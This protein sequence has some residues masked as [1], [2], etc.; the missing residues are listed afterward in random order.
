MAGTDRHRPFVC[1]LWMDAD[2]NQ[3]FAKANE[4]TALEEMT[5]ELQAQ[6]FRTAQRCAMKTIFPP[7]ADACH[8]CASRI[9][10]RVELSGH[11]H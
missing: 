4:P 9:E 3:V 11:T 8:C 5:P 6:A 10:L 2:C 7:A 1:L